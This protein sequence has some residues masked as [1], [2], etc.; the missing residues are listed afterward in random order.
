MAESS[1]KRPLD[2]NEPCP[3]DITKPQFKKRKITEILSVLKVYK[4]KC[5]DD[6]IADIYEDL[7]DV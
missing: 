7:S 5:P 6:I 3:L 4:D 1:S 2:L